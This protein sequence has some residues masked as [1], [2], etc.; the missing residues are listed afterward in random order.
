MRGGEGYH[1]LTAS[2]RGEVS[3]DLL[4]TLTITNAFHNIYGFLLPLPISSSSYFHPLF[5]PWSGQ[6]SLWVILNSYNIEY[7]VALPSLDYCSFSI[8]SIIGEVFVRDAPLNLLSFKHSWPCPY[9]I[10]TTPDHFGNL[11]KLPA[12]SPLLFLLI[13][14]LKMPQIARE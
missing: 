11:E 9:H 6:G 14:Q 7:L 2:S 3:S 10:T 13:Q 4:P 12:N 5:S 8:T 1:P